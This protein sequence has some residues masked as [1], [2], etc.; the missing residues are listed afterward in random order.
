MFETSDKKG[1]YI[2]NVV[3]ILEEK[4]KRYLINSIGKILDIFVI[5]FF[6]NG[7]CKVIDIDFSD[8]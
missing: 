2:A 6:F 7:N 5:S 1:R 8:N 3:G 4:A